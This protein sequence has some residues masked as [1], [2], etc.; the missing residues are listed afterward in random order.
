MRQ[1]RKLSS[2][3]PPAT[4]EYQHSADDEPKLALCAARLIFDCC[5]RHFFRNRYSLVYADSPKTVSARGFQ[6]TLPRRALTSARSQPFCLLHWLRRIGVGSASP[7]TSDGQSREDGFHKPRRCDRTRRVGGGFP[8][9]SYSPRAAGKRQKT[10]GCVR[11]DGRQATGG[12][13]NRGRNHKARLRQNRPRPVHVSK[14]V[15]A[16][17]LYKPTT[18]S[19]RQISARRR[20][21]ILPRVLRQT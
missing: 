14:S 6:D 11:N 3:E 10:A 12:R 17:A 13:T 2:I 18:N 19:V 15:P 4:E 21:S 7:G 8:R 16:A 9:R 20:G 5:Y 1:A